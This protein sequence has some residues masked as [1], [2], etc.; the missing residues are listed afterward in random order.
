MGHLTL[1]IVY[2]KATVVHIRVTLS[3]LRV[4]IG[5]FFLKA[6]IRQTQLGFTPKEGKLVS[7]IYSKITTNQMLQHLYVLEG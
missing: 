3:H 7:R 4:N 5:Y 1:T 2:L 6:N